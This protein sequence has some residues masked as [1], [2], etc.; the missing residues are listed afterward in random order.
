[1][2]ISRAWNVALQAELAKNS[3]ERREEWMKSASYFAGTN[4]VERTTTQPQEEAPQ[5]AQAPQ[6]E[7]D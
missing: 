4:T 6:A 1:M 7:H 2:K 3:Y 5:N